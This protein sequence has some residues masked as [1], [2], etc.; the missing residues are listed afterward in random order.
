MGRRGSRFAL[1]ALACAVL[2]SLAW[3]Q[4]LSG[5]VSLAG[6]GL[7]GITVHAEPEDGSPAGSAV[8]DGNG[9]YELTLADGVYLLREDGDSDIPA[10]YWPDVN[11]FDRHLAARL[12]VAGG[13][14][15]Q[16]G[17]KDFLVAPGGSISGIVTGLAPGE[18]ASVEAHDASS[19]RFRGGV[20]SDPTTGTY[21]I[22]RLPEGSY[23]IR[24]IPPYSSDRALR[25]YHPNAAVNATRSNQAFTIVLGPNQD[26]VGRNVDLTPGTTISGSVALPGDPDFSN[27][28]QML[29]INAVDPATHEHFASDGPDATGFYEI[30]NLPPGSYKLRVNTGAT[31]YVPVYWPNTPDFNSG[32]VVTSPD[33][34]VDFS[35]QAG[36]SISG[37]VFLDLDG[38]NAF[39]VGMDLPL[40]GV[41]VNADLFDTCCG[42][43]SGSTVADGFYTIR[44]L[45][46][47]RYRV[48]ANPQ[49]NLIPEY[50]RDTP[51]SGDATPVNVAQGDVSPID[52][53]IQDGASQGVLRGRVLNPSGSEGISGVSVRIQRFSDQ[54]DL[55]QASTDLAGNF[56][57]GNL[58]AGDFKVLFDT[59]GSNLVN[60]EDLVAE[61]WNRCQAS[62]Q[63]CDP[64]TIS[65][66]DTKVAYPSG[67]GAGADLGDFRLTL[68]GSIAGQV[69]V[70][71]QP[72]DGTGLPLPVW[73]RPESFV[74]GGPGLPFLPQANANADGSYRIRGLPG[75]ALPD[76]GTAYRVQADLRGAGS[77]LIRAYYAE[78]VPPSAAAFDVGQA[79]PILV[80]AGALAAGKDIY[81]FPGGSISGT[82]SCSTGGFGVGVP[83]S[84]HLQAGG[85]NFW[86][87]ASSG[88]DGSYVVHGL[89]GGSYRVQTGLRG[90]V[91]CNVNGTFTTQSLANTSV[92][93]QTVSAG[94]N[95]GGVDFTLGA[96]GSISGR[97]TFDPGTGPEGVVNIRV[98]AYDSTTGEFFSDAHTAGGP[99]PQQW[100]V[101]T[102]HALPLGRQYEVRVETRDN[103][104][105]P[106]FANFIQESQSPVPAGG[107][108]TGDVAGIDFALELGGAIQG[109]VVDQATALPLVGS[110]VCAEVPGPA[111]VRTCDDTDQNGFYIVR[112]LSEGD[113]RVSASAPPPPNNNY[114]S[115]CYDDD[116]GCGAHTPVHVDAVTGGVILPVAGIDFAL[117]AGKRISG[118]VTSGGSGVQGIPVFAHDDG[119]FSPAPFTDSAGNYTIVGVA[120]GVYRVTADTLGSA[121]ARGRAENV[122]VTSSDLPCTDGAGRS[123]CVDFV[124]G[125]GGSI[126][127]RV[128]RKVGGTG[129][130]NVSVVLTDFQTGELYSE[131]VYTLPTDFNGNYTLSGLA[132]GSYRAGTDP[133]PEF[134]PA[135]WREAV[136]HSVYLRNQATAIEI[137]PASPDPQKVNKTGVDLELITG[138]LIEGRV[139]FDRNQNG[140]QDPNPDPDLDEPGI[141]NR[142]VEVGS[143][144]GQIR[145]FGVRTDSS[146]DYSARVLPTLDGEPTGT[147]IQYRVSL[148]AQGTPYASEF[149]RA[150]LG[151]FR[152]SNAQPVT[153][154]AA[155][156]D[157]SLVLGGS[158]TGTVKE[159]LFPL[160]NIDVSVQPF[161]GDGFFFGAR[162]AANGQYL[163]DG[164][165]PAGVEAGFPG[166][167][168]VQATDKEQGLYVNEFW[169]DQLFSGLADPLQVNQRSSPGDT[170]ASLADFDLARGGAIEGSVTGP[171]GLVENASI[172]IWA[173]DT[174]ECCFG[175]GNRRT[176][177]AEGTFHVSG[178]PAGM[179]LRI[180]VDPPPEGNL[181]PEYWNNK[182][183]F[184]SADREPGLGPGETRTGFN[185]ALDQGGQISGTVLDPNGQ[186]VPNMFVNAQPLTAGISGNGTNTGPAGG[187]PLG[188]YTIHGL[189]PGHYA[190]DSGHNAPY[191]AEFF[192]DKPDR[193]AADPVQ[194]T[195]GTPGQADFVLNIVPLVTQPAATFTAA[196]G[197][198]NVP[199]TIATDASRL[200]GD[201]CGSA[202]CARVESTSPNV[203][204][205]GSTNIIGGT[206]SFSVNVAAN[207]PLGSYSFT[208]VNDFTH[209][210]G[211]SSALAVNVLEVT[212][213]GPVGTTGR[214]VLV[215]DQ[216]TGTVRVYSAANAELARIASTAF[217]SSM[218]ASVTRVGGVLE[219]DRRYAY[220]AGNRALSIID[221][222]LGAEVARLP[223]PGLVGPGAVAATDTHVY[224]VSREP[225]EHD[226]I[227]VFDA[228]T[229]KFVTTIPV[230]INPNGLAVDPQGRWL[231]VAN[232]NSN[233]ISVVCADGGTCSGSLHDVLQTVAMPP[234]VQ[235]SPRGI[236]F[237]P[238]GSK[239]YVVAQRNT[240][241]LDTATRTFDDA[242]GSAPGLGI[243]TT[244]GGQGLIEIVTDT[245]S[246]KVLAYVGEGGGQVKVIDTLDNTILRTIPTPTLDLFRLRATPD[247]LFLAYGSSKDVY[248][249]PTGGIVAGDPLTFTRVVHD[250]GP[251]TGALFPGAL[252]VVDEPGPPTGPTVGSP[253]APTAH[254][255][256]SLTVA[257]TGFDSTEFFPTVWLA[258][259]QTRLQVT[260]VTGSQLDVTVPD[261]T[262]AGTY[263]IAVTNARTGDNHSGISTAT[264]RI[265][266]KAGYLPS[267][268]VLA[269]GDGNGEVRVFETDGD[270][271]SIEGMEAEPGALALTPDGRRGVVQMQY[272]GAQ[273]RCDELPNEFADML[274]FSLESG[275]N[276]RKVLPGVRLPYMLGG[277][278]SPTVTS[279]PNGTFVYQPNRF[280]SDTVSVIDP[281]VPQE[282]DA[283]TNAPQTYPNA[284]I[285]DEFAIGT[286][287]PAGLT[288]IH[289]DAEPL[290]LNLA[291]N[292]A[293]ATPDGN[294]LY[295]VNQGPGNVLLSPTTPG[296]VSLIDAVSRQ[297]KARITKYGLQGNRRSFGLLGNVAAS[298]R[299]DLVYVTGFD[300]DGTPSLF[301]LKAGVFQDT[302]ASFSEH[303]TLHS[304]FGVELPRGLTVSP[305]GSRIYV[306][307][308]LDGTL[309]VYD[310]GQAQ[311][312]THSLGT[313]IPLSP[314]IGAAAVAAADGLLYVANGF[315]DVLHVVDMATGV[316]VANLAGPL[317]T[318]DVAVQ[319]ASG[320]RVD[321]VT[322]GSGPEGGGTPV[323][324]TGANFLAGATV[325]FGPDPDPNPATNVSVPN[326]FTI[327]ATVPAG[328][329]TDLRVM[330]CNPD[331][332]CGSKPGA[333]DYEGDST[334]PV[335]T[336]PPYVA[337]QNLVNNQVT[338]EIRWITDEASSSCV[339]IDTTPV[340]SSCTPDA[341]FV[342]SH[343]VAVGGLAP[344]TL[345]HFRA[346]SA[347]VS[348]NDA[349]SAAS[350]FTTISLPDTTPPQITSGPIASTTHD[351]ALVQWLTDEQSS[352]LVDYDAMIDG[353]FT[354]TQAGA[355]GTSHAVSLS[356]LPA[357]TPHEYRVRS[358]DASGNP[359][360]SGTFGFTTRPVPDTIPPDI[361]P[362]GTAADVT[363][364]YLSNNLVILTWQ[365]DEPS[366]SFVNYGVSSILENGVVDVSLVTT[367]L[368][369]L[370]NLQPNTSYGIQVGSTDAS[371]NTDSTG[372]PFAGASQAQ[373]M[374]LLE[375]DRPMGVVTLRAGTFLN[376][377]VAAAG[378]TTPEA[379]D[380]TPPTLLTAPTV[381]PSFDRVLI[382]ASTDEAASLLA[383]YS[384]SGFAASAFEPSFTQQ[385]SL[386]ITGLAGGTTYDLS[387]VFTD[388]KGNA[389]PPISLQFT[390]PAAPDTD[391]PTISDVVVSGITARAAVVTWTT[392]E[393]ADSG[394]RF[395]P[396]G[397][398]PLGE[399]GLLG[400][401]LSHSLVLTN[402]APATTYA[403]EVRSRDASGNLRVATGPGFTTAALAPVVT[404]LTPNLLAQGASA[405]VGFNGERFEPGAMV[406]FGPDVTV[407]GVVVNPLGTRL[408]ADV[409]VA[410]SATTGPRS[411]LVTNPVSTLTASAGFS[412]VDE[413]APL[414]TITQPPAQ[415][416]TAN[417]TVQGTLSEPATV[418]V[419]GLPATVSN[420]AFS[421]D[422][423]LVPGT[424]TITVT[425]TDAAGNVGSATRTV[426]LM[427][428]SLSDAAPVAEDAGS[429]SFS[430]T[431]SAPSASPVTVTYR[432]LDGS[433]QAGSDY[434][435]TSSGSVMIPANTTS[436]PLPVNILDDATDEPDEDF[437]VE[438][439]GATG[440]AVVG[441]PG[442]ATILDNDAPP[443][444]SVA[445]AGSLAEGNSGTRNAT[446]TVSLSAPSG[447][448]VTVDYQTADGS[449]QAGSDY[450]GATSSVDIPPGSTSQPVQ[451]AVNG[452]T[453][454]EPDET[455]FLDL[456]G[457]TNATP[458][459]PTRGGATILNDDAE[460]PALS[461]SDVTVLEQAGTRSLAVFTVSLSPPSTGVV[462]VRYTTADGSAPAASGDYTADSGTLR[463]PRGVTSRTL[464]IGLVGDNLLEGDEHFFVRLSDPVGASIGDEIGRAS[465]RE[466]SLVI[467]DASVAEGDGGFSDVSFAVRLSYPAEAP[468]TGRYATVDGTAAAPSDY[469][470]TRGSLLI[471]SGASS[472]TV[473]V[474][475][476]GDGVVEADETFLVELSGIRRAVVADGQ[477]AGTIL[478]DDP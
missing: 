8:T 21:T 177:G 466:L 38:D 132:A 207:A 24:V 194:V 156:I 238:G 215:A 174:G 316:N 359:R 323:T 288:R 476:R 376:Q 200:A 121:Y 378:F 57:I 90:P 390:T 25:W 183:D 52:F 88:S 428:V 305:D 271:D 210:D 222:R 472:T 450:V 23:R 274:V 275:P 434:A 229:W 280:Q 118:R 456:T 313:M 320:P 22:S 435:G 295:V 426:K 236:A 260:G 86:G 403:L 32:G 420:L 114:V 161:D 209:P 108:L 243:G 339:S 91:T 205:A 353:S 467:D 406:D 244:G 75:P 45:T 168:R 308:R 214:R 7:P 147:P 169:D 279:N 407:N 100:G 372:D 357:N 470:R 379:P 312:P 242:N 61:Y 300:A 395:G 19:G 250:T 85:L 361:L 354:Q 101:Y 335:Y 189:A 143:F 196:Q 350:S 163:I 178:I 43:S 127:G 42:G 117:A 410:A 413:S 296:S 265:L 225:G 104:D 268:I 49:G 176:T 89:P 366:T 162:T 438:L 17:P 179:A 449:A 80:N 429:A 303:V 213:G 325:T 315:R 468:V 331:S 442:S 309:H 185:F 226:L 125:P 365:T 103:P 122:D 294:L 230:G 134:L 381:T 386:L 123:D 474:R 181:V 139:F 56:A 401:R 27:T 451:V 16:P 419:N 432:T 58:P 384:A 307:A 126:S 273:T 459:A 257:G 197:A 478:N 270:I 151:T 129:V 364:S 351:S 217:P 370:T 54:Q 310:R 59:Q 116:V 329:G 462:T 264:L 412:I 267:Q 150:P 461:I 284:S 14:L 444:V 367:H 184:N 418:T 206:F 140:I 356:G 82:V 34:G 201:V 396:Q 327:T 440:A 198:T 28:V 4:N 154:P 239:A 415:V 98:A 443:T 360:V 76:P 414:V 344:G 5:C 362:P 424:N 44:G 199:I 167:Y 255:N 276:F 337:S 291:P 170:A 216:E 106:Q 402:L 321:S 433:A 377:T 318:T 252:L 158:I 232:Q 473:T 152:H 297:V 51:F 109:R 452:D 292:E 385:P 192:D 13:V 3:A 70:S 35:L 330:V 368:V 26:D 446:F 383:Q 445:D 182:L 348:G 137:D 439:T 373:G 115:E 53:G 423:T 83:I 322:P 389:T 187:M 326:S 463:F 73:V 9:C 352:S 20:G 203:T 455:F 387:L 399:A 84:V 74:S 148:H 15:S 269:T 1:G 347:D 262:P 477:A 249:V 363:V 191:T 400:L 119:F 358:T 218:A 94:Q 234:A 40:A 211:D 33:T 68:G 164:L 311:P 343:L 332:Q 281:A 111:F 67:P 259:S 69:C 324:L 283:D 135:Y 408:D 60:D 475:V 256:D 277:F 465:I 113:Y 397:Q 394:V 391:P 388:P 219:P 261:D 464:R 447:H 245:T 97:V 231:Y 237:L 141:P 299:G 333:F 193:F 342:T 422:L 146:G 31:V 36:N 120:P 136:P 306:M 398:A 304:S 411:V 96:A 405:V 102:I 50:W 454:F 18:S 180:R 223:S 233:S 72:C 71:G 460:G 340:L 131:F 314:G 188:A 63:L 338:A 380:A 293:S 186:P 278:E 130:G 110:N 2:P 436:Y 393:P 190:L 128:T 248:V 133:T 382:Q 241:V 427:Q 258:G 65:F 421:A 208:I 11:E 159:G 227:R 202:P 10:E 246:A 355:S 153:A 30:R 289:L 62:P 341:S 471:P 235:N 46:P 266:P 430:L 253:S 409:T 240:Y 212:P 458:V 92:S 336:T 349:D 334:D 301:V 328:T 173:Y 317:A 286:K 431:L 220:V 290:D 416:T 166:T 64:Q 425:A 105:D 37:R 77:D 107:P 160:A 145:F 228:R 375:T 371:G 149:Y 175:G 319:A 374:T 138:E 87:N 12:V 287:F 6:S 66:D 302:E 112:G 124:L 448:T 247:A 224:A 346:T 165:P 99:D 81:L 79:T 469:Q 404:S 55:V 417:V 221:L 78:P 155:G 172:V 39:D 453:S 298:P 285:C 195:V 144:D 47:Q 171:L 254:P 392:S 41:G 457:A 437:S 93:G 282:L 251:T 441:S 157:L 142:N 369:F 95:T 48:H 29:G 272:G 345:Y 204:I 263:R